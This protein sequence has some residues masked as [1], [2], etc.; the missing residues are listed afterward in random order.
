MANGKDP[1]SLHSNWSRIS[2]YETS[3]GHARDEGRRRRTREFAGI[4][5][6]PAAQRGQLV[7]KNEGKQ[8]GK[9][10]RKEE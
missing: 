2:Q 9:P 7:G 6:S 4:L 10:K 5:G 8:R 3:W 1:F